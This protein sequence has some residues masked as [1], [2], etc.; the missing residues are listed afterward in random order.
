VFISKLLSIILIDVWLRLLALDRLEYIGLY[1]A[2]A[3]LAIAFFRVN[4]FGIDFGNS[5]VDISGTS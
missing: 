4:D 2:S 5:Y 1:D 3:K